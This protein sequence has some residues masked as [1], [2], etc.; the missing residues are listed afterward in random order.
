MEPLFPFGYGLSYTTF[1]YSN[2]SIDKKEL[3]DTDVV[4]VRVNVKNTGAVAGQEIVQLYV[5]DVQSSV[6]RPEKELK[7]FEKV[8]L[9]PGEEKTVVF[10]LD[11]RAFA[12]YNVDLKDWHVE[13]GEF[14]ILI[15]ASSKDIRLQDSVVVESAVSVRKPIHR[16]TLVGD[17]LAD[18]LL[19]PLAKD[20][21]AKTNEH[22]PLMSALG[23]EDDHASDMFEAMMKYLPLRAL[24]NFSGGTF[25]EEAMA[26][27]IRQLNEEQTK[28]YVRN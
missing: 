28:H 25:T 24:S 7:G 27:M 5:K 4:T 20:L 6:V 26:D 8:A 21:L 12:Y 16:N 13:T 10:T 17:L 18:P 14:G 9:Q 22:N 19:A 1:E 11:K 23:S 2:L 15:G 3:K